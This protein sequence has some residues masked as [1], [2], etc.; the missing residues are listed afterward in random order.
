MER[1]SRLLLGLE[2]LPASLFSRFGAIITVNKGFL[3]TNTVITWQLMRTA[4]TLEA[5]WWQVLQGSVGTGTKEDESSTGRVWAAG[6]HHVTARCRFA[7]VLKLMNRLFF[8]FP[9][10]DIESAIRGHDFSLLTGPWDLSQKSASTGTH[11]VSCR[12]QGH[13]KRY[14]L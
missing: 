6:Y 5:E 3:N 9:S 10:I 14:T 7:G 4:R 8:Y 13:V 12:A 2:A 11:R 1:A